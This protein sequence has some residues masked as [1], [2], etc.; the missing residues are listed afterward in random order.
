MKDPVSAEPILEMVIPVDAEDAVNLYHT[1][2]VVAAVAPPQDPLIER[3]ALADVA[4]CKF[5]VADDAAVQPTAGVKET[6]V[7]QVLLAACE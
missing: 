7:P 3:S 5:P 6:A 1:S 4:F 2:K